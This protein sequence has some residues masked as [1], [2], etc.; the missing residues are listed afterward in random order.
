[1]MDI[2]PTPAVAPIR[3]GILLSGGGRSLQYIHEG[4]QAGSIPATIVVVIASRPDAFGLTRAR[5]LG[6]EALVIDYRATPQEEF[7]RQVTSA[8][9]RAR[10]DLVCMAGRVGIEGPAPPLDT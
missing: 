6:Y 9:A 3:L 7:D 1:M 10:V 8:L 5:K 4:I 2:E